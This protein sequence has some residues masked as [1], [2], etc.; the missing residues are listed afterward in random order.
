ME[1]EVNQDFVPQVSTGPKFDRRIILRTYRKRLKPI[2]LITLLAMILT[3]VLVKLALVPT[4]KANC[5]LIRYPK[6]MSTP[7]EMPYLYQSFDLNTIL[8]TVRTRNVILEVIRRLHMNK[9]PEDIFKSIDVERGN[10]SNV[11]NLSVSNTDPK[12]ASDIAN[13]L[14]AVFIENNNKLQNSSTVKIYQYYL[15][16][17]DERVQILDQAERDAQLFRDQ[18]GVISLSDENQS[19][20]DVLKA[21]EL[22]KIDNDLSIN[23]LNTK[24]NDLNQKIQQAPKETVQSYIYSNN[25]DKNLSQL[26]KELELLKTKYTDENPKVIKVKAQITDLT[27]IISSNKGKRDVPDQVSYGPNGIVETYEVD[28]TRYEGALKA[29][30]KGSADYNSQMNGLRGQLENLSQLEKDYYELQ[31]RIDLNKDV[32]RIIEGRIAESKMALESNVSDFDILERA[33]EPKAPEG[34]KRKLIVLVV[35]FFVFTLGSFFVIGKELLDFS[36]KS[37]IDF[38]DVMGIPMLGQL[39]DEE[40]VDNQVFYRNLQILLDNLLVR[41]KDTKPAFITFCSDVP[42]TG[43]TFIIQ[44]MLKQ[45]QDQGK[46]IVYIDTITSF[47]SDLEPYII[48][49]SLFNPLLPPNFRVINDNVRKGYFYTSNDIFKTILTKEH[50][51]SFAA[52]LKDFDMIIWETFDMGYNMQLFAT[53]ASQSNLTVFVS[54]FRHSGRYMMKNGIDFLRDKDVQGIVGILNYVDAEYFDEKY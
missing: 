6:N 19:K 48:N 16:Q 2:L 8:E 42:E 32:L 38:E 43:K 26:Q 31:R 24:I 4:W 22:K 5:Y 11:L 7:S 50:L 33:R 21:V 1:N 29:A 28:K 3:G 30:Q 40:Q 51:Q 34:T 47:V 12:V 25:D 20:F 46:K 13:M 14:A 35:G 52:H 41:I 10:R 44:E 37:D 36:V 27:K 45:I 18:H 15:K 49:D 17:R 53:I 54:R 9:A 39:P 23:E